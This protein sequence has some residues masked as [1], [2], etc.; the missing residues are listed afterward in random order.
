MADLAAAFDEAS[1]EVSAYLDLDTGEV[2]RVTSDIREELDAIYGEMPEDPLDEEAYRSAFTAALERRSP[3]PWMWEL[4]Q[5]ADLVE[6]GLG[7]RFV[8][9]PAADSREGYEDMEAFLETVANQRPRGRLEAALRGRG[10]CRR[11][12][13]ALTE[14]P[15]ER[16]R[17]FAFKEGRLRD[18]VLIWLASEGIEPIAEAD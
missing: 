9:V 6:G 10:A 17:W 16:E 18:R 15:A 13:D 2:I 7:R 1:L 4:L 11:F 3:P 14:Y 8:E 5:E 12:K